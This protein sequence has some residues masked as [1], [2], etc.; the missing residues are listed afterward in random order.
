MEGKNHVPGGY[1]K[2]LAN[3]HS[4]IHYHNFERI[5]GKI[6]YLSPVEYRNK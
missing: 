2:N 1:G 6:G 4:C 3:Q 5:Q